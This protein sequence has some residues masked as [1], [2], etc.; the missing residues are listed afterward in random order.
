MKVRFEGMESMIF[1]DL[2]HQFY[3]LGERVKQLHRQAAEQQIKTQSPTV[4]SITKLRGQWQPPRPVPAK[5]GSPAAPGAAGPPVDAAAGPIDGILVAFLPSK[6]FGFIETDS[7]GTFFVYVNSIVDAALR[8]QLESLAATS[9]QASV[10]IGVSFQD[11][12]KTRP[13][14]KYPEA[15]N[16]RRQEQRGAAAG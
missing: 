3:N 5:P 4:E 13:D 1:E 8:A 11:A 14:A 10:A 12:G 16:V 15:K 9:G 7:Q 6:G 2:S